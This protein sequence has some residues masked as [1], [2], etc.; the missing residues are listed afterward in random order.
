MKKTLLALTFWLV[1]NFLF[2]QAPQKMSYQAVI[3]DATNA[4]VAN[5]TV[6]MQ[7]SILQG[8]ASGAVVYVETHSAA[9]NT[10]GLVS[11]EIGGG[12]LVSGSFSTIN[13]A[14]G[15]FFIKTETD[16]TG[17]TN[18]TITGTTQLLSVPYAMYA[19][20]GRS[21]VSNNGDTL[22]IG[23]QFYIIPGISGTNQSIGVSPLLMQHSCGAINVHNPNLNYGTMNDQ[24]GNTYK[25]IIIG[26]QE[27]MA[28][29]LKTSHYRN[30]DLITTNLTDSMWGS[31]VIGA[32]CFFNNDSANYCCPYGKL[33]N[34]YAVS[35]T[36]NVCPVG[37]HIPDKYEGRQ[38]IKYL[39]IYAD[40]AGTFISPSAG[41]KLK[42]AGINYWIS[43]NTGANNASGFSA[44]PGGYRRTYSG[45]YGNLGYFGYYWT[46]TTASQFPYY[47]QV[48]S[49]DGSSGVSRGGINHPYGLSLRCIKD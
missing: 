43:P 25:T 1:T 15:P 31:A 10:N 32:C 9:T 5:Q 24:D 38:L 21:S 40:T 27:W 34:W 13:W 3:R 39:D 37:W 29:N 48:N 7:V 14:N 33:Y 49:N 30:G 36:R 45:G 28:E 4:L 35:D 2:A 12:T 6:G 22:F 41:E 19:E 17:G 47:I 26:S 42:N 16:P 11:I 46:S 20:N 8:S 44:L 23:N 18:Y